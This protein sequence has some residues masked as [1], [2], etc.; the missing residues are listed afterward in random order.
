[1]RATRAIVAVW[2]AGMS[3]LPAQAQSPAGPRQM[4]V[5]LSG[6]FLTTTRTF[7]DSA[8]PMINAEAGQIRASYV[9][10]RS[11]IFSVGAYTQVWRQLSAGVLFG[12]SS[13]SSSASITA[14]LPHPF[15]FSRSRQVEGTEPDAERSESTL[16]VLLRRE[17]PVARRRATV[18]VFGGPAWLSVRQDVVERINYSETYPYDTAAFT[19]AV[20]TSA[21][22]TQLGLLVGADVLHFVS[23]R[24]GV[25]AGVRYSA[26]N[27]DLPASLSSGV[28]AI[29]TGGLDVNAGIRFRF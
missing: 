29:K 4:L 15:F 28:L 9:V 6:G 21:K 17:F 22:K 18:A 23:R 5:E 27:A 3:A 24:L 10:P 25:G 19:S 13:R 8:A 1:M 26:T 20:V 12:Q 16:A 2:L 11:A 7:T 14:S